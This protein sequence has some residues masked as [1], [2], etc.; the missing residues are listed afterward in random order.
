MLPKCP[1]CGKIM[2]SHLR[3][4]QNFVEDSYW[5]QQC[6]AYVNF[7]NKNKDKKILVLEFGV[8]FNTPSIIRFPF[9]IKTIEK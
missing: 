5:H 7:V 3:A 1:K 6:D 2:D 4:S 9:E 8:G